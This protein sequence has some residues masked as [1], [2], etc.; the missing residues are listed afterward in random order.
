MVADAM[1]VFVARQPI[2]DRSL[3]VFAYELLFRSGLK[4]RFDGTEA[5]LATSKLISSLYAPGMNALLGGKCAFINFS[6]P[7]L[8]DRSALI[9]PP[10]TTVVEVLETVAPERPVVDACAELRDRGYRIALDDFVDTA[11]SHP[12]AHLADFIKVDLRAS[13]PEEQK[14]V[15][16]RYGSAS[17]LLAEKVETREEFQQAL[18]MGFTYFQGYFFARPAI[19]SSREA[20]G[21]KPNY[22]R[23]LEEVHRQKLDFGSLTRRITR[24]PALCYKLLRFA[25]SALFARQGSIESVEQA[26]LM[27]G[28]AAIRRWVS[29]VVLMDLT[30]DKPGEIMVSALVRARFSELL[31]QRTE[32]EGRSADLFLLGV[33]SRLDAM[34]GRPLEEL[35]D[36]LNPHGDIRGAL[37]QTGTRDP[38]V[39]TLWR[40]V[41]AY[42]AA[43]WEEF[44]SLA[45]EMGI[46]PEVVPAI[47]SEAAGWADRICQ[48]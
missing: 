32:L 34:L 10:E 27:I 31:S 15:V 9:L 47:Y 2:F 46:V 23:I 26:L 30:S 48:F 6:A 39:A 17:H 4:N 28:E 35:L 25:N 42:E 44:A 33:L 43:G 8:L 18:D 3:K 36:G 16:A 1:E 14:K 37:L 7:L 13:S 5:D 45:R 21:L 22:L 38:R 12:L 40:T 11:E 24:E 20:R 19:T 41:L 29:V